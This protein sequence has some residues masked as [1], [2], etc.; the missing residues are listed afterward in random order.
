MA[1]INY[2]AKG[3]VFDIQRFSV[4]DGPGIR[5]IV[6]LKG[7]PLHCLWCSNPESQRVAPDVLFDASECIGC[8]ECA[9]VCPHGAIKP[10]NPGHVHRD[11]CVGCGE[12]VGVCPTGALILKG[13]VSTVEEVIRELKKDTVM[14]RKSGGGITLS[15]GEPLVQWEF[16]TELLK[17][18]KAQ[19]WNTAIET[20]GFAS[21]EAI[22]SVIPWIDYVLLDCKSRDTQVHKK[23]VGVDNDLIGK[24]SVRIAELGK[25]TIIRVPTIPKVNA[26]EEDFHR[27]AEFAKTLPG[28]DTIHILP[29][30]RYGENKYKLLD[31]EYLMGQI[32]QLEAEDV[33]VFKDILEQ[34]GFKCMIG[35]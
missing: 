6:F 15:G 34:H 10:E 21:T 28:V 19:G 22:E 25:N 33:E 35:G 32:E 31:R 8:G 16:A 1:S 17:A 5:T 18:C 7:C 11:I 26:T 12:C 14:Y 20:T 29:Y 13:E 4:N 3:V 2:K 23:Y 9:K 30:H 27:I 24:N